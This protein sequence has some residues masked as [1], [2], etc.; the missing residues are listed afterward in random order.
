MHYTTQDIIHIFQSFGLNSTQQTI[1][2]LIESGE[3]HA[4]K[5]H[6]GTRG[7]GYYVVSKKE[8]DRYLATRIPLYPQ[9]KQNTPQLLDLASAR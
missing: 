8:M 4:T 5:R 1:Y 3:L 2:A 6:I 9:L 7:G